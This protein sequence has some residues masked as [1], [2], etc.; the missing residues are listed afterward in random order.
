MAQQA[1]VRGF[2]VSEWALKITEQP[3]GQQRSLRLV[4]DHT[5]DHAVLGLQAYR[6]NI[7]RCMHSEA[8]TLDHRRAGH[9]DIGVPGGNDDVTAT[10]Q[11]RIAG[12]TAA[13]DDADPRR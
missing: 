1:L 7:L 12:K 9:A 3:F 6:T 10:G 8:R 13:A 5:V 2:P 4:I 11:Y